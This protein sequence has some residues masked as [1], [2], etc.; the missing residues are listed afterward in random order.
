[1]V[2]WSAASIAELRVRH[3]QFIAITALGHVI[4]SNN[5][6]NMMIF[7]CLLIQLL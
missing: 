7:L 3:Q 6:L 4:V 1:L 5:I 2:H